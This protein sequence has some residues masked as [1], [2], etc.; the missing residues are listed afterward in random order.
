MCEWRG[1]TSNFVRQAVIVSNTIYR[2]ITNNLQ[3]RLL[4]RRYSVHRSESWVAREVT[5]C[6]LIPQDWDCVALLLRS[7]PEIFFDRR[8]FQ[9]AV[10]VCI[11]ALQYV[12]SKCYFGLPFQVQ[13]WRLRWHPPSWLAPPWVSC[14]G[15]AVSIMYHLDT[16]PISGI[17]L[18]F[19][20]RPAHS[21]H[22]PLLSHLNL[23]H[24]AKIESPTTGRLYSSRVTVC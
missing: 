1:Q 12:K 14:L 13:N 9:R 21:L 24:D 2:L 15:R 19:P 6:H 5:L 17:D 7:L 8:T 10:R 22:R 18:T 11:V 20:A 23:F 4:V 3:C 16:L